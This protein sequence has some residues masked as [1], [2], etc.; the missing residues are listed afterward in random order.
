[1]RQYT[2]DDVCYTVGKNV[3]RIRLEKG[4]SRKELICKMKK[5]YKVLDR[6]EYGTLTNGVSIQVLVN[7]ADALEVDVFEFFQKLK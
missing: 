7:I 2:V 1:M 5:P 6:L 3:R 4:L